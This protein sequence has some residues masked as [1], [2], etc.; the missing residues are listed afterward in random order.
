MASYKGLIVL[1]LFILG[2]FPV[3]VTMIEQRIDRDVKF[4]LKNIYFL[5]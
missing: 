4:I 1:G 3:I 2:M 5:V